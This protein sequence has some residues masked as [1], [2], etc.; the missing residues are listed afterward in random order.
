MRES[1]DFEKEEEKETTALRDRAYFR[2]A[3][4]KA[5]CHRKNI[6]MRI[7]GMDWFNKDGKYAKGKIHCGC[8]LC[9]PG[10]RFHQP[11][12]KTRK[13]LAKYETE[14]KEYKKTVNER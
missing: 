9:K 10:K 6:C 12:L 14:L 5:I 1:I 8:G 7:Y 4:H 2:K 3:R 11:S 13:E